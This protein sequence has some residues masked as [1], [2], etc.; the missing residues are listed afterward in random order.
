MSQP[1]PERGARSGAVE[2]TPRR[3]RPVAA[4]VL[5]AGLLVLGIAVSRSPVSGTER[6]VFSVIN[7]LPPAV[8]VILVPIMQAGNLLAGPLAA[9]VALVARRRRLAIELLSAGWLAWFAADPI[10]AL[11]GR[12]RPTQLMADAVVRSAPATGGGFP[13]GHVTVAAAL[14]T[15]AAAW[16]PWRWQIPLW[17][18]VALVAVARIFIGAHLPLDAVGGLLLGGIVGT[19][20]RTVF[21]LAPLE[22]LFTEPHP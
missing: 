19:A 3:P 9:A 17:T 8:A 11:V 4:A 12:G 13:S 10:K 2:Q 7:G 22:A 21:H 1:Q 16:V 5:I 15:V 20:V 6:G 18:I 14:A